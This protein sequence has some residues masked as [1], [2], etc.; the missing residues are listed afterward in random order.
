MLHKIP[1]LLSF[2]AV[3]NGSTA[4]VGGQLTYTTLKDLS[5]INYNRR[6]TFR[7]LLSLYRTRPFANQ[8]IV[9]VFDTCEVPVKTDAYGSFYLKTLFSAVPTM[10]QKVVLN[11]TQDVKLVENLYQRQVRDIPNKIIVVSDIDDTLM[12]SFIYRKVLKFRTLMFTSIEKRQT[13]D[14]MQ[15]LLHQ[16]T[17]RG[18]APFYLS[19][20]EQNLYPLIYRFLMHHKFPEGPLFLK[21]MRSL[22]DVLRNIKFPILNMHKQ[23]T[24]EE[25]LSL[26]RDKKFVFMG[27]NTQHDLAIYLEAAAKFPGRVPYIIIRKVV[28]KPA[29]E[30]II[31]KYTEIMKLNE[32]S[33]H[34]ADTFPADF[35]L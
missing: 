21:K 17:L 15:H 11:S 4:L 31:G 16:I 22:W 27:D 24:L 32:T 19:N 3:L 6:R 12:H 23:Q 13:V 28:N 26:F 5:F 35:Q 14:N 34:Y 10:L 25:L 9:L 20:S 8:D 1:I 29:D 7:T 33:L 18:A 30:A 2:Y